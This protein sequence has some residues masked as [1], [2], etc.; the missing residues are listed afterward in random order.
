[1]QSSV[2][3][4]RARGETH[5]PKRIAPKVS[6]PVTFSWVVSGWFMRASSD[7]ARISAIDVR[8]EPSD[9]GPVER[10]RMAI[11]RMFHG[12]IPIVRTFPAWGKI[13]VRVKLPVCCVK[14][15]EKRRLL[16]CCPARKMC[17]IS[18]WQWQR[19]QKLEDNSYAEEPNR[20]LLGGTLVGTS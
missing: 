1:M 4:G 9:F 19:Q 6:V 14:H 2:K 5:P 18:R 17:C 8:A 12:R 16:R 10:R 3:T 15:E 13:G 7:S 11:L 20:N